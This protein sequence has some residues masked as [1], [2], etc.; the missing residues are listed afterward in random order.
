MGVRRQLAGAAFTAAEI[1]E[2][3]SSGRR[4]T[5]PGSTPTAPPTAATGRS[6]PSH[7]SLSTFDAHG[8]ARAAVLISRDGTDWTPWTTYQTG[9][10]RQVLAAG[11]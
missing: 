11:C 10:S 2:A 1:A 8:N 3:E 6:T 7:G 4:L 5:P 9:A